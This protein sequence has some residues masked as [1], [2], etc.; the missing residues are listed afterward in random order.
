V[1]Q[2]ARPR[3]IRGVLTIG[4]ELLANSAVQRL[5]PHWGFSYSLY[6]P[7]TSKAA[8]GEL[9]NLRNENPAP[10]AACRHFTHAWASRDAIMPS[11]DVATAPSHASK[12]L[13]SAAAPRHRRRL[14]CQTDFCYPLRIRCGN[15]SICERFSHRL[16]RVCETIYASRAAT[17]FEDRQRRSASH[18][19]A[20]SWQQPCPCH[21]KSAVTPAQHLLGRLRP[22]GWASTAPLSLVSTVSATNRLAVR[23]ADGTTMDQ[24]CAPHPQSP[25]VW[26]TFRPAVG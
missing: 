8:T 1:V 10:G 6:C 7:A 25:R 2:A 19:R 26:I 13:L 17:E 15:A 9:V 20:H 21:R 16:I 11:F 5:I 12:A 23:A 18:S 14:P 22:W 4:C 3:P 24:C